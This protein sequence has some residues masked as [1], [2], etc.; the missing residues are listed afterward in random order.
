M[1]KILLTTAMLLASSQAFAAD[2]QPQVMSNFSYDYFEA[3]IGASQLLSVAR[4]VSQSTR[5]LTL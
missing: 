3:R 5:M 2:D 1:R 4:S